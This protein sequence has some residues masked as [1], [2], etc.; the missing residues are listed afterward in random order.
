MAKQ[1]E[2]FEKRVASLAPKLFIVGLVL[3]VILGFFGASAGAG[4]VYYLLV[5]LGIVVGWFN[6][7]K[8]EA[9]LYLVSV[10]A[11]MT[12]IN[13]LTDLL[14]KLPYGDFLSATLV[15]VSVFLAAGAAVVALRNLFDLAKD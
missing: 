15:F 8:S 9:L 1:P 4:W 6:V 2:T 3:S 13:F 5:L 14:N 11:L 12:S 7:T 10:L